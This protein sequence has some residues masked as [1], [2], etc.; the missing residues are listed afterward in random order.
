MKKGKWFILSLLFAGSLFFSACDDR[1]KYDGYQTLEN[2]SWEKDKEY[3]FEFQVDDNTVPYDVTFEVR[4]NNL[5]PFQNLWIFWEETQP[6]GEVW[7]DTLE[8]ILAD[9][10]GKWLG[11]GMSVYQS[12]FALRTHYQFPDTGSY[13]ISIRQGM[14]K[15]PLEGIQQIGIRVE[16]S[17]Q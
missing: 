6:S 16:E 11:K 3:F 4:N 7:R 17:E 10:Y 1:V 8:C 12:G 9:D 2:R 5:Y 14:R 13:A 15:S